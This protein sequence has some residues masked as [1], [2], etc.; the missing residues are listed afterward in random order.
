M[1]RPED[2]C[3][4]KL[5]TLELLRLTPAESPLIHQVGKLLLHE[6]LDLL[7]GLFEAF[8]GSAGNV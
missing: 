1:S 5:I 7:Y 4:P 2:A 8:L 6:L 3:P